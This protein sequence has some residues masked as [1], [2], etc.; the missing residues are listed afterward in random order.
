MYQKP[1]KSH[2]NGGAR[3]NPPTVTLIEVSVERGFAATLPDD[4]ANPW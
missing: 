4:H 2:P 3:Y 1:A